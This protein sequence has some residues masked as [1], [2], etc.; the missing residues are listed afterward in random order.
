MSS[1]LLACRQIMLAQTSL[2]E[3]IRKDVNIMSV[4]PGR[5]FHPDS[6]SILDKVVKCRHTRE[7]IQC[8]FSRAGGARYRP[9]GS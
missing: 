1:A 4:V 8:T 6:Q 5:V 2:W 9:R 3:N 7:C